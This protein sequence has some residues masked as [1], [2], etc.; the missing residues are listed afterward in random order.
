MEQISALLIIIGFFTFLGC[1]LSCANSIEAKE[2]ENTANVL[3][4][5]TA[6]GCLTALVGIVLLVISYFI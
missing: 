4:V 5:L 6:L 2:S 3:G 1:G